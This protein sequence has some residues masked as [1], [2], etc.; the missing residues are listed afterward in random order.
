MY[1]PIHILMRWYSTE[2]STPLDELAAETPKL[3]CSDD[4]I[5]FIGY[6]YLPHQHNTRR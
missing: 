6:Y 4:I 1:L 3:L 5:M 2:S